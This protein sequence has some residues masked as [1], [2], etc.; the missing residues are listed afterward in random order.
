MWSRPIVVLAA[1]LSEAKPQPKAVA[2]PAV[3]RRPVALQ[4]VL[5]APLIH[6]QEEFNLFAP[7]VPSEGSLR[8][9]Q[10]PYIEDLIT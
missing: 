10:I 8:S 4:A 6:T 9:F 5:V 3:E 7:R 2:E 1:R